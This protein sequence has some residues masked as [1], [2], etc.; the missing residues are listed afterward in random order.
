M[1]NHVYSTLSVYDPTE[2]QREKLQEISKVGI[3]KYYKPR[4]K[5]QDRDWETDRVLY[6]WF[7]IAFSL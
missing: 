3:C 2:E 5:D 4:P 6:T 1:P 7:G